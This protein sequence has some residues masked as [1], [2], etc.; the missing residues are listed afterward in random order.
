MI[1]FFLYFFFNENIFII[2][3]LRKSKLNNKIYNILIYLFR[4]FYTVKQNIILNFCYILLIFM[5]IKKNYKK[6]LLISIICI[7]NT[8]IQKTRNFINFSIINY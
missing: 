1:I 6:Y 8:H 4:I 3:S 5:N 7:Y 2:F